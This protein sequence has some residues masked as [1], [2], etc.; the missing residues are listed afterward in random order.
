M[1]SLIFITSFLP[2]SLD[3]LPCSVRCSFLPC[4]HISP[5]PRRKA[6]SQ[7]DLHKAGKCVA[8]HKFTLHLFSFSLRVKKKLYD[9]QSRQSLNIMTSLDHHH[10]LS[11][12]GVLLARVLARCNKP[13]FPGAGQLI[14][15]AVSSW[16]G[17]A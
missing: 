4:F 11:K 7:D 15:P 17:A 3:A 2:S 1:K 9:V 16:Y 8:W 6:A 5:S 12:C 13:R 10:P 14:S